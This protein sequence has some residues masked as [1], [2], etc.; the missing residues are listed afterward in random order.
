MFNPVCEVQQGALAKAWHNLYRSVASRDALGMARAGSK[1]LK[2]NEDL[3]A[4]EKSYLIGVTMLGH[5]SAGDTAEAHDVWK[6]E[7]EGF[8]NFDQLDAH[9]KLLAG[10]AVG[11]VRDEKLLARR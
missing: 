10:I 5:I 4:R 2:D 6:S 7:A 9:T 11:S 1:L 8:Y 3:S